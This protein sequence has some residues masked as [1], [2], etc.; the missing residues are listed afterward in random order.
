SA[1]RERTVP[2]VSVWSRR[3]RQQPLGARAG[4]SPPDGGHST[5]TASYASRL[6][7]GGVRTVMSP[8][9]RTTVEGGSA[10]GRVSES[11][12]VQPANSAAVINVVANSAANSAADSP[13]GV[14]F[15]GILLEMGGNTNWGLGCRGPT[16][17]SISWLS[18][19]PGILTERPAFSCAPAA[20]RP[21][22]GRDHPLVFRYCATARAGFRVAPNRR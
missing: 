7:L 13:A 12:G 10:A 21:G 11:C 9:A 15:I 18:V 17:G 22:E 5:P 2:A 16:G 6:P 20:S 3:R 1:C 19:L 4:G 8:L 14:R